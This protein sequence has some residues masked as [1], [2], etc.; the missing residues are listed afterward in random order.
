MM[1]RLISVWAMVGLVSVL[2]VLGVGRAAAQRK[3][4]EKGPAPKQV[5][6]GQLDARVLTASGGKVVI[7]SE[8]GKVL[9]KHEKAGNVHDAWMLPNG[10]V[11]FAD[12]KSVTEV[13][14]KH[15]VVFNYESPKQAGGGTYACQRLADGRTLIGENSTGKVLEVDAGGKV[16][17][18]LQTA[19][20]KEGNHHNMRMARK[21]GSGN[22]LVCQSGAHVVKEYTPAGKV[23]MEIAVDSVAFAAVRT[24]GG[25]TIVAV[26]DK[27]VEFDGKGKVVWEFAN[28]D[29]PGVKI[30]SMT[31]FH[32][33]PSGNIVVGCY[34]AYKDGG[35]AGLFEV[36]R[37]KKLIWRY[38]HPAPAKGGEFE[39]LGRSMMAVQKLDKEGKVLKGVTVR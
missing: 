2:G 10:N 11:L 18:E 17:F 4:I 24:A 26:I 20:F 7:L 3:A 16:V 32:V 9:W 25:S 39:F 5:V 23:V 22:Y 13:T 28:T 1:K 29:I 15:K 6:F 21:L 35:Q 37:A 31:G 36:S 30:T 27:I 12:G 34:G 38:A 14:P 33:L 8:E 19:P